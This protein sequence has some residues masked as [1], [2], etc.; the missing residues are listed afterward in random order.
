[1]TQDSFGRSG[2]DRNEM[3]AIGAAAGALVAAGIQELVSRRRRTPLERAQE[4]AVELAGIGGDYASSLRD[5]ASEYLDYLAGQSQKQ[6]KQTKK[7]ALKAA[8]KE[9][10]QAGR[11]GKV[12]GG[13]LTAAA[14]GEALEHVVD[15]L[16][17]SDAGK[18][19]KGLFNRTEKQAKVLKKQTTKQAKGLWGRAERSAAD[20]EDAAYDA[21]AVAQKAGRRWF[22]SASDVA[23]EYEKSAEAAAKKG[24]KGARGWFNAASDSAAAYTKEADKSAQHV[25][26]KVGKQAK[27]WFDVTADAAASYV[28]EASSSDVAKRARK[29]VGQVRDRAADVDVAKTAH[30]ASDTVSDLLKSAGATIAATVV[31]A[32]DAVQDTK[33]SELSET[34]RD[35]ASSAADTLKDAASTARDRIEDAK[36]GDRA[37]DAAT[38]ARDYGAT[39]ATKLQG[40]ASHVADV[41]AE[42]AKEARADVEKSVR[43]ARRRVRWGFRA[44][45]GGVLFGVLTAPQSGQHTRETLQNFVETL[46]EIVMPG[47]N[48]GQHNQ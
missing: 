7:Q 45:V 34:A 35:Y 31:T 16:S 37:R 40:T 10:K 36:L 13:A 11:L 44:F 15:Y 18:E 42:T 29:A 3:F 27:R 22:S 1:M 32:R 46:L 26:K 20:Y 39:T 8:H 4:R 25:Q 24:K 2:N 17:G 6:W 21:A 12:A 38:A 43:Q 28:D 9:R 5:S 47:L 48:G 41:T 23:A 33:L 30:Q 14:A 19:A